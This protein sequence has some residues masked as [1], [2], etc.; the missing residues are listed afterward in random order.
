MYEI[1]ELAGIVAMAN[2]KEQLALT[3]DIRKS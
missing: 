2:E 3:E 1:D